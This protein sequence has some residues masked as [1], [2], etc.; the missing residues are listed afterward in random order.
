MIADRVRMDAY[1]MALERAVKPESVVL[2]IGAGTGVLSLLA[3]KL[4]ARRVIAIE[5]SPAAA[6]IGEAARDNGY[7]DRIRV[8]QQ[9]STEVVLDE[10]ADVIVSD[11]RGVLPMFQRHVLDIADARARLLAPGGQLIPR[12][13]AL[14]AAVVSAPD[15]FE[16]ARGPWESAPFGLALRS[17]LR[18]VENLWHKHYAAAEDLL[19]PAVQWGELDYTTIVDPHVRGQGTCTI[20]RAGTAHG[21][22]AWFD[23]QLTEGVGFSNRPGA[24]QAIYGQAFF[25]WPRAVALR[26]GD[27]VSFELRADPMAP[28][29]V[30]TWT[31]EIHAQQAPVE[32]FRQSTFL[33]IPRSPETLR[34]RASTFRPALSAG[35]ELALSALERMRSGASLEEIARALRAAHPERFPSDEAA[36]DFTADLS[37]RYGS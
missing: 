20:A 30:W 14:F 32:R 33:G 7:A 2:D 13:D 10:P 23:A 17:G 15:A 29:Y 16:S 6:L 5:P 37:E 26:A 11:L 27:R 31:T 3:C 36:F 19:A 1:A 25:P 35:G 18:F 12:S 4:G 9:R 8:V 34:K 21:L 28:D 24:P 22:L